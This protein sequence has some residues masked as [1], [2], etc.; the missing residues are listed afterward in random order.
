[1]NEAPRTFLA[2]AVQFLKGIGEKR[3]EALKSV[4]IATIADLFEYYPRRYLD[5]S[6]ITPIRKLRPNE[7]ATV[8]GK[9]VNSGIKKG[10]RARFILLLTDN[11]GFLSCVWFAQLPYW[12]KKFKPGQTL[13]VSGKVGYFGGLQMVHPEFDLLSDTAEDHEDEFLHTGKIIPLYPS[14]ES[15]ARVGLDSRGFR[16]IIHHLVRSYADQID[17]AMPTAIVERHHLISLRDAYKNIHFPDNFER[18]QQ[19]RRRLK[20]DELFF[21]QLLLAFRKQRVMQQQKMMAVPTVGEGVKELINK[22]PFKLTDAQRK[23]LREIYADLKKPYP[24]YRLLQGD[25]GSGKTIVALVTMLMAIENGY[26]TAL[27]APTE[28]LAEQHYLTFRHLLEGMAIDVRLLIGGQPKSERTAI[29]Q[30]IESGDCDIVVG[31]HAIIQEGV[32]FHRLGLVVI[33]EQHRFGVE[34][35]ALLTE[36]GMN[37]EVLVMTATPIPRT[38]SLTL[39]GDLDVSIIDELPAGR[40]PVKTYWRYEDKRNEIYG[41]VKSKIDQGQQAYIV[42]PLIEESEKLDL[43]AAIDSY[44]QMSRGIFSGY[45]LALLH[46]RM[47]SAEKDAIMTAFKN[48]DIQILVSTTVIEVGVDVPTAT[49]MVIENAERFGLTQLHQ[50]RGRV[51]RGAEQSYCI[52]IARQGLTEDALTRLRTMTETNDGFKIAEVDLQLRGPGELFG[53]RQHGMPDLKIA[54]PLTDTE[55]LLSA[56]TEAFELVNNSEAF[57]ALALNLQHNALVRRYYDKLELS[58]IG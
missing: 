26:Q 27:M 11:T 50:L 32:H 52:L 18:L 49:V 16:R 37:P 31:T 25:V 19:A 10:A 58:G 4:G 43:K 39:Y 20:F 6:H 21:M 36:K 38:L 24:M 1:M 22:L 29:M 2:T 5:R 33:D 35:R 46:G 3:A 55:L 30:A 15:L 14:S 12:Q 23:V 28:I 17:D 45:R 13:A 40:V 56:R 42:F 41:F 57:Y 9:V 34:Q 53:T 44:E 8:V 7:T 47:K 48:G 54:D 51:G